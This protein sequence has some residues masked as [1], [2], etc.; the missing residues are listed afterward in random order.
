MINE[1]TKI[2]NQISVINLKGMY[3]VY[4][5]MKYRKYI[6]YRCETDK[7]LEGLLKYIDNAKKTLFSATEMAKLLTS[8]QLVR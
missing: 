2:H 5:E 3:I 7:E 4:F 8:Y 6:I 1:K